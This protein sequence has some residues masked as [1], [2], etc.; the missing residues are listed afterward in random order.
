MPVIDPVLSPG[1]SAEHHD[2]QRHLQQHAMRFHGHALPLAQAFP[3]A[4]S[5]GF[6]GSEPHGSSLYFEVGQVSRRI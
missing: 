5:V 6:A 1:G 2:Q 3:C 4:G